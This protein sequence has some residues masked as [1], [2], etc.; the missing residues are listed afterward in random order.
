MMNIEGFMFKPCI[1]TR[2]RGKEVIAKIEGTI[3][4]GFMGNTLSKAN[5]LF[6]FVSVDGGRIIEAHFSTVQLES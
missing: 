4:G 6:F 2:Y 1:V 5:Q 3:R